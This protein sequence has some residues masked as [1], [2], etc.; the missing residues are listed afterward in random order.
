MCLATVSDGFLAARV[1]KGDGF[2]FAELVRRYRR[3]IW[4]ATQ[5]PPA[6]VEAE[7][8]RQEALL[9]LLVTC[10]RYDRNKGAFAALARRNVRQR[11]NGARHAARARKHL[12]L[13]EA[14][15]DGDDATHQLAERAAAP[16]GSDPSVVVELRDELRQRVQ[17][18]R[19][20]TRR[21]S[22]EQVTRALALIAE[23]N[24]IKETALAIGASDDS[25]WKWAK[26]SGQPWAGR[27]RFTQHEISKVVALVR[28]GASLRQAGA[29]VG[30][31]N[32]AVLRWVRAAA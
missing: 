31:S 29:A 9:G 6:G 1:A 20:G 13:N 7:D 16:R 4:G 3:L 23:G 2:A 10:Q 8:L 5:A 19:D 11:V 12:V 15:R 28:D 18:C 14:V 30:A 32:S 22:A 17:A 27:R 25:V 21:F 24:T 26:R